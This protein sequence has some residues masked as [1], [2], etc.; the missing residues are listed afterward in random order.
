MKLDDVRVLQEVQKN[1]K[2]AMKAID[3]ISEKIYDDGLSVQA[4]R[5]SMKY[6]DIY[7]KATDR[8]LEG[9]A[10]SYRESGFQDMMVKGGVRANTMLN[11]STSHIAELLIQG[12]NRGLTSMWKAINHHENAGNVSME[13]AKELMDFEEK[14]IERLKHYL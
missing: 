9:R 2:M 11:T 7:N 3:T 8:L 1:T 14:N 13:V 10:A 4:A 12:S 5:E 6:A